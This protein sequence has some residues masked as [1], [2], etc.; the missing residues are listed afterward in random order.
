MVDIVD[1]EESK[2][3]Q[4]RTKEERRQIVKKCLEI[5]AAGGDVIA[6]LRDEEHYVSAKSTWHNMQKY[7]LGRSENQITSGSP[8]VT[9]FRIGKTHNR[10]KMANMC[11][12]AMTEGKKPM[13]VMKLA[14]YASPQQSWMDLKVWMKNCRPDLY[15]KIPAEYLDMRRIR[16]HAKASEFKIPKTP[17]EEPVTLTG[18]ITVKETIRFIPMKEL[19]ERLMHDIMAAAQEK[20]PEKILGLADDLKCVNRVC[21]MGREALKVKAV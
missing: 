4:L 9:D 3:S 16:G 17:K 6:Y 12:Q 2:M 5:E 13:D 10:E 8:K 7:D 18:P 1:R 19:K 15:A 14:G 11:L 20:D 21:E